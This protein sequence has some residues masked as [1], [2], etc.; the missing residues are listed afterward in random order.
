MPTYSFRCPTCGV[1]DQILPMS[2]LSR[3]RDCPT[4]TTPS[5]RIY[6]APALTTLGS[7]LHRAADL[8]A[9]SAENP[10]VVRRSP[11]GPQQ[12][13]GTRGPYPALPRW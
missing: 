8:A 12:P 5:A 10:T 11:A 6:A 9:S 13:R 7:A 3:R 1:F 2:E 4:C